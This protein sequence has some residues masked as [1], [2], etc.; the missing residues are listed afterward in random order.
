MIADLLLCIAFS[1]ALGIPMLL[2]AFVAVRFTN[3]RFR[4]SLCTLLIATT[5]VA[6]LLGLIVWLGN[7]IV[8]YAHIRHQQSVTQSLA[9]WAQEYSKIFS[10]DDAARAAHMIEYVQTYYVVGDGYGSTP[11]VDAELE[12]QRKKT[13]QALTESLETYFGQNPGTRL[14][15]LKAK[16]SR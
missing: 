16:F 5:L 3:N 7:A 12:S 2:I 6:V 10:D 8:Q 13:I 11:K 4:F 14:K 15:T 1:A 9:D